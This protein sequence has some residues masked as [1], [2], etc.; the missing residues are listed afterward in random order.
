MCVCV[1]VWAGT[2]ERG[3]REVGEGRGTHA[4]RIM[5]KMSQVMK[6]RVYHFGAKREKLS[7]KT[8]TLA[9]SLSQRLHY[10]LNENEHLQVLQSEIDASGDEGGCHC[11]ADDIDS[12]TGNSSAFS[13]PI[14]IPMI[15]S[16]TYFTLLKGSLYILIRP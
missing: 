2:G 7:P 8:M 6:I 15:L 11:Q 12:E 5:E 9:V 1:V 4:W 3:E 13:Y 16:K 14:Y 10:W